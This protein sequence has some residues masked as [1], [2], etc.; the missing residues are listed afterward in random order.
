MRKNFFP[1]LFKTLS[2]LELKV[3]ERFQNHKR[4]NFRL[5]NKHF[6]GPLRNTN[7]VLLHF[8]FQVGDN[9]QKR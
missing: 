2:G 1:F 5:I 3:V 7:F 9:N 6:P 8:L 4:K